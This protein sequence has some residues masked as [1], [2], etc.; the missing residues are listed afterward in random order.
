MRRQMLATESRNVKIENALLDCQIALNELD[1]EVSA[2]TGSSDIV[3]AT[4]SADLIANNTRTT[5]KGEFHSLMLGEQIHYPNLSPLKRKYNMTDSDY[6][7]CGPAAKT[8][9]PMDA[10]GELYP[11]VEIANPHYGATTATGGN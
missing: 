7:V 4:G 3:A 2:A 9:T 1:L 10:N 8:P 6:E 11:L 5:H